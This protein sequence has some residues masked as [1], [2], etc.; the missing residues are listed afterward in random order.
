MP[1]ADLSAS[2]PFVSGELPIV[3][4]D[5]TTLY[6]VRPLRN[7]TTDYNAPDFRV[8]QDNGY[9]ELAVH[10]TGAVVDTAISADDASV[11]P[12]TR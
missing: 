7:E 3:E 11:N 2:P 8:S 4:F 1:K 10:T 12:A 9:L 5:G 6:Y